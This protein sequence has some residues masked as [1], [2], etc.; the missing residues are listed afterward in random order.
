VERAGD[1]SEL[2]VAV[3]ASLPMPPVAGGAAPT[4]GAGAEAA[5]APS[6]ELPT[7]AHPAHDDA[8]AVPT[9]SSAEAAAS[10]ITAAT[11]EDSDGVK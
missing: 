7:P 8:S 11:C 4:A 5:Y 10:V 3:D 9:G 2:G 6:R 1:N